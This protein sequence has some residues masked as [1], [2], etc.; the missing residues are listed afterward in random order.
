M[1]A[2]ALV[3]DDVAANVR[4]LEARLEAEYF[5]VLTAQSGPEALARVTEELPDII[6]LDVMM[7]GMDGFEVCRRLKADPAT[8]HVPVV[9]VTALDQPAD[10]V[11]GLEAGADDFLT[12]PVSDIALISR[13]KSLVR[14]KML[15]DELRS[16]A[17]TSRD[18]GIEDPFEEAARVSGENGRVLIV[19][20]RIGS[21]NRML[22]AL[23]KRHHV[24]VEQR[25]QEA[26]F[27]VADEE[28]DLSIVSL[29]L[30]DFDGLRLCSQIRSL[31]RTRQMPLLVAVDPDEDSRLM[32]ALEL[33]VN[34]YIM[35]PID[36]N[37]LVARV[38]TQVRRRRYSERLRDNVQM[39]VAM[40]VTDALT[41]LHNRRYFDSHIRTLTQHCIGRNRPLAMLLLDIDHF[42]AVNDTHG[43]DAGD[44]VLKEF[45]KR[46][47]RQVR[48][49][50]LACRLGGEE[51]V[52][53][54][55][56]TPIQQALV[57]GE[58]IRHAMESETF[59]I[60]QGRE[61]IS[62][63][64]SIGASHLV[65]RD[66]TPDALVKRADNALYKAK[67]GGRNQ[68]VSDAA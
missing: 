64:V 47:R 12:K 26:L 57:V 3:V 7:P 10:R 68:V 16:R 65:G 25:P 61:Q 18:M 27:R 67:A 19:D 41:G 1:S 34:D 48:G 5:E 63:T 62:V 23:K 55:P 58:R 43:H 21:S 17:E 4:L 8:H 6:L 29:G 13:V 9:M 44:E 38:A 14:L 51:F 42:K 60:H 56:E 54:M 59:A 45:A 46:M 53:V 2:R 36:P 30:E 33:G 66:D 22:K 11:R 28:F 31:E 37:E 24:F 39:S 32:R 20:D 49:V 40:A 35:R 52:V 50:D 15:T